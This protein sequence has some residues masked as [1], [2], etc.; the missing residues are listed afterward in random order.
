MLIMY[1]VLWATFDFM[2]EYHVQACLKLKNYWINHTATDFGA[3]SD[4][5]KLEQERI[6]NIFKQIG[7]KTFEPIVLPLIPNLEPK[8][9]KKKNDDDTNISVYDYDNDP[10]DELGY[11]NIDSNFFVHNGPLKHLDSY[12]KKK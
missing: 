6:N 12:Y 11:I 4:R 2:I 1:E 5:C 10:V 8:T 7:K 9:K 3:G